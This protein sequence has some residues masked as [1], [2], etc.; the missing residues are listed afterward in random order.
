MRKLLVGLGV[1]LL[2]AV[3]GGLGAV[4]WFLSRF[5][6]RAEIVQRVE[7]ATGRD[8]VLSGPVSVSFWPALGFRG[9]GAALAN[10]AGGSAPHLMEAKAIT[11]GVALRPLLDRRLEVTR[12]VLNEPSLALEV[13]AEG[14]PNWI[15]KPAAPAPGPARPGPTQQ[16]VDDVHLAADIVDGRISYANLRTRSAYGVTDMNLKVAM[17]G[18]EAP[19][20]IKGDIAYRDKPIDLDIEVGRVRALMT[21]QP[22]PLSAKLDSD[23]F[24]TAL[25]GTFDVGTGALSGDVTATGPSLRNL[26][27]WAGSPFGAGYGFETFALRGKLEVGPKR[28]SFE[29]AGVQIDDIKARGDFTIEHGARVPFLSGRLEIADAAFDPLATTPGKPVA[30]RMPINLNPYFAAP[31]PATAGAEVEVASLQP[32]DVAAPG[33]S[34]AKFNFGWLKALNTNLELTTGPLRVQNTQIDSVFLQLTVLD[35][36]L[37]ATLQQMELYGGAGSG[38]FEVDARQPQIVVRNEITAENLKAAAFFRDAFGFN[39]LDGAA[40]VKW[41]FASR[42]AT[43][44]EMM[45]S[46]SGEGSVAL[47]NG[48]L[49]G[50]DLGGVAKTIR[51]AL[52][53]ELVSASAKTPF[54]NLSF[55]LKAANGVIATQDMRLDARDAR[56]TGMGVID[57]GARSIDLRLVPR[58][59]SLG[60]AVPFRVSGPW[61]GFSYASDMFGR[62]RGAEAEAKARAMFAAAPRR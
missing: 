10:V 48:S 50:V 21:G 59:G 41:A 56:L 19:L 33:W 57:A 12:F 35:G 43:Q 39:R 62:A 30:E 9:E 2:L 42:G 18:F 6:A 49:S 5:D 4:W 37:A 58:L 3:A 22:T 52:R 54:T 20:T 25:A 29:N 13:D 28:F 34:E 23:I 7:A 45:S 11:I 46:L 38:R 15:L 17:Q 44:K 47:A 51:N 24:K 36:Y 61:S 27:T 8:F 26:A 1:L 60:V 55:S 31:R 53:R 40:R 16:Q 32:V 14:R